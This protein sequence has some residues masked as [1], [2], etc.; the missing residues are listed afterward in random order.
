MIEEPESHPLEIDGKSEPVRVI[1]AF[2]RDKC[3]DSNAAVVYGEPKNG[4][5]VRI[6]SRC[7]YSEALASRECDC[8][9]QLR[10]SRELLTANGGVLIYLDQEGRGL[11]LRVKARAYRLT[12]ETSLDTFEA[13]EKMQLP[14]DARDYT[15]AAAIL[16][17]LGLTNVRLLTNNPQKIDALLDNGIDV[18]HV[19]LRARPTPATVAYLEAKKRH[20]HLL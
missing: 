15:E 12:A 20:G 1:A 16:T 9:W 5:L 18:T 6:H 14:D 11:G 4:C 2:G 19:P 8:G 17:G 7:L 10:R 13:Y 3:R